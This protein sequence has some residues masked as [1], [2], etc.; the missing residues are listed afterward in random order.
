MKRLLALLVL[1]AATT[2]VPAFELEGIYWF[3]E[4]SGTGSVGIDGVEGTDFDVQDDLGYGEEGLVGARFLAGESHQLEVTYLSMDISGD[5]VLDKQIRFSDVTYRVNTPVESSLDATLIRG[6]YRFEGGS[7]ETRAGFLVGLQYVDL[8]ADI[9]AAGIGSAEEQVEVA[10]PVFGA[11]VDLH[12]Q[13][14]LGIRS[15]IAGGS[16]EWDD[17]EATFID[18]EASIQMELEAGPYFGA[19]YRYLMIDGSDDSVPLEADLEFQGPT[20]YAG[21]MF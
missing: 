3:M 17:I 12:P 1:A 13:P 16:W 14:W 19:G 4:P 10:M 20:L 11:L 2:S 21:L 8:D 6:A 15:S 7:D 5:N 18:F 9:S